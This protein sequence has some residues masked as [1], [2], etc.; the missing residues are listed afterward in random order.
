[1]KEEAYLETPRLFLPGYLARVD[2]RE[3]PAEQSPDGLVMVRLA[4]G[5]HTVE[6]TYRPAWLAR[7]AYFFTATGWVG[8]L[9]WAGWAGGRRF[10]RRGA[11]LGLR[12]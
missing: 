8:V 12:A 3:V 6:L 2:G 1:V 11:G 7:A 10:Q 4:P 5:R 9:G